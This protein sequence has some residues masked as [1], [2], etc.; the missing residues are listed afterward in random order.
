MRTGLYECGRYTEVLRQTHLWRAVHYNRH[1]IRVLYAACSVTLRT[2]RAS[3]EHV[4]TER[5]DTT[6]NS[7][8]HVS[9]C[10]SLSAPRRASSG[11]RAI[12][13]AS[14]RR[15]VSATSRLIDSTRREQRRQET[16]DALSQTMIERS[17][18]LSGVGRKGPGG[19][20][21]DP[22]DLVRIICVFSSH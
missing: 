13:R 7:V 3:G 1:Y 4:S 2:D 14:V 17:T 9:H 10:V 15:A 6:E 5:N 11:K 12:I 16:N 22:A 19:S 8:G 20:V 18:G 21:A